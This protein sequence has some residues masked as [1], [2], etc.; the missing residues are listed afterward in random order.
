MSARQT[1]SNSAFT[2][3]ELMLAV[4]ILAVMTVV[5][6]F[7]FDIVVNTWQSGLEVANSNNEGA[8][9]I[10][11]L[12]AGLRSAYY[13]NTGESD[14][15]YGFAFIDGGDGTY[16]TDTIEWTKMGPALVGEDASFVEMPHRVVVRVQQ[17]GKNGNDGDGLSVKAWR[18]DLQ[19]DEFKPDEDLEFFLLAP[20]VVGFNCRMLDKDNP[21]KDEEPNWIDEWTW[22]N[23]IPSKVELT[24][25]LKPAKEKADPIAIKRIVDIPMA[26]FSQNPQAKDSGSG[27]TGGNR[28][29]DGGA[30]GGSDIIYRPGG[31]TPGG[32][33]RPGGTTPGGR[34]PGG[35]MAPPGGGGGPP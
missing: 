33:S 11:Q 4:S 22:S 27:T 8:Y 9:A 15:K 32:N 29:L 2:L 30:D 35:G 12:A 13:P 1:K 18:Q 19:L 20:R 3:L 21:I 28:T 34:T 24:I 26:A 25:Y 14:Y 17:Y 16:T 23:S 31:R 7:C 6:F 5:T 10:D